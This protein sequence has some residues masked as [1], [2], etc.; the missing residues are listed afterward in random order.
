MHCILIYIYIFV[1]SLWDGMYLLFLG[2]H[3]ILV[4]FNCCRF[5]VQ[6]SL[7]GYSPH[8]DISDQDFAF[9]QPTITLPVVQRQ[10]DIYLVCI[11]GSRLTQ[12]AD[13]VMMSGGPFQRA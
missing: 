3:Y 10:N 13:V 6:I 8:Q 4:M 12:C 11:V 1:A 2:I 5:W 7:V 9:V